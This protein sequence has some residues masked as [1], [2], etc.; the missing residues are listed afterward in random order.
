[1]AANSNGTKHPIGQCCSGNLCIAPT[2]ELRPEHACPKCG[3]I[4]HILCGIF[5]NQ[6]DKYVCFPCHD[7]GDDSSPTTMMLPPQVVPPQQ[8]APPQPQ[9]TAQ[10]SNVSGTAKKSPAQKCPACGGTDHR[11]RTSLKCKYFQ[12]R[13][14]RSPPANKCTAATTS[15]P[16]RTERATTNKEVV[17][18]TTTTLNL[19]VSDANTTTKNTNVTTTTTTT[20][21][22]RNEEGTKCS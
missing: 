16:T 10:P 9:Q 21:D 15:P 20:D 12:P 22:N 7:N 11:R 3:G 14:K 1:M 5:D 8:V 18:N 2:H 19:S 17:N 6:T 4:V 13:K